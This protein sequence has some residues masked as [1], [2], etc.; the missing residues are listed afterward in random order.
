MQNLLAATVALGMLVPAVAN[1]Q[2]DGALGSR[3]HAGNIGVSRSTLGIIN[4]Y[5]ATV[6]TNAGTTYTLAPTDSGT[7]IA[8]SSG[9]AVTVTCPATLPVGFQVA[10]EQQ[11]AGAVTVAAGASAT[12]RTA[13]SFTGKTAGQ[14][15]VIGITV[16][17]N[18][19]GN[20]AVCVLTG[21][22]A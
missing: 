16:D 15:S 9:S 8:F 20:S 4:N 22:A 10:I 17:G 5:K 19:N 7:F 2:F 14:F 11:G 1:A 21:D 18:S 13:H 6:Q 3:P 12:L